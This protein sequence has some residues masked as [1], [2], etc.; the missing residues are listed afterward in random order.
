VSTTPGDEVG[1]VVFRDPGGKFRD[2]L[3]L[4]GTQVDGGLTYVGGTRADT[5]LLRGTTRV[6]DDVRVSFGTQVEWEG[7][8]FAQDASSVIDGRVRVSG[9]RLGAD[10]ITLE[11]AV[12]GDVGLN[13]GGGT[14]FV[15]MYGDFQGA[16]FR[17]AGGSGVDTI[18]YSALANS[19]GVRFTARLGDGPDAV[20]FDSMATSPSSAFID[21]GAGTDTFTGTMNPNYQFLHLP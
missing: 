1:P 19:A 3:T 5:I 21:F 7:S 13:L 8:D 18:I 6:S 20:T 9:G 12:N 10:R 11:G 14:N 15:G 16:A 17:Y 4:D 2:E